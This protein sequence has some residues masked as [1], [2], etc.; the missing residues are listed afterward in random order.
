M[1]MKK[2]GIQTRN[3][4]ISA[5]VKKVGGGRPAPVDLAPLNHNMAL[6][7]N[8]Q[9]PEALRIFGYA[10]HVPG[11]ANPHAHANHPMA[12]IHPQYPYQ[13]QQPIQFQ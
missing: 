6:P 1:T 7:V 13:F 3:R 8:F 9:N 5:K 12:G 4:K 10:T 2:D 11:A